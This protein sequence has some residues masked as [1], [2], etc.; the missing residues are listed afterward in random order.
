MAVRSLDGWM[1]RTLA[2][3]PPPPAGMFVILKMAPTPIVSA[4]MNSERW[5][6]KK[7]LQWTDSEAFN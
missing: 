3:T 7:I 5:S 1:E 2:D 6:E 4:S